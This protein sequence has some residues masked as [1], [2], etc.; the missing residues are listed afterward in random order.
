MKTVSIM[1][2]NY[3]REFAVM[4]R[5]LITVKEFFGCV[6]KI[7]GHN[8]MYWPTWRD[9]RPKMADGKVLA[10]VSAATMLLKK[11]QIGRVH[12]ITQNSRNSY[13]H[14]SYE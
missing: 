2:Y 10:N 4:D 6:V 3:H 9:L 8:V 14:D 11:P 1:I 12:R 5:N 13:K 7:G